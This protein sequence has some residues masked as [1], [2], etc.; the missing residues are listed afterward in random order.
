MDIFK[1]QHS[2]RSKYLVVVAGDVFVYK[3]EKC[4][5]DQPFLSFKPIQ[6]FCQLVNQ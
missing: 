1:M 5:F 3:S 6:I 2:Y 4:K